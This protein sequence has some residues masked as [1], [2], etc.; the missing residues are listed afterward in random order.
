VRAFAT[1]VPMTAD[2]KPA[3]PA[4]SGPNVVSNDDPE[5]QLQA[6]KS[7]FASPVSSAAS[8]STSVARPAGTRRRARYASSSLK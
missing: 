7:I 2:T 6:P 3:P 5:T 8:L 1:I 4:Q